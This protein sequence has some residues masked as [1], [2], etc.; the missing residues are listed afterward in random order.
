MET[1][2]QSRKKGAGQKVR[3]YLRE[4]KL[5]N[6]RFFREKGTQK[7]TTMLDGLLIFSSHGNTNNHPVY[8]RRIETPYKV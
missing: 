3:V 6:Y 8:T 4:E 1:V 7:G 5:R 2:H